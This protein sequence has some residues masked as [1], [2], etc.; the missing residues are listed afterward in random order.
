MV[1]LAKLPF[2]PSFYNSSILIT[3]VNGGKYGKRREKW[4]EMN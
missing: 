3:I 4:I 2:H 1:S